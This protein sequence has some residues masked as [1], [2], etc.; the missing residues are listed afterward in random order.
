MVRP[1]RRI[2]VL[3]RG[4][5][6]FDHSEAARRPLGAD[7]RQRAGARGEDLALEG[8]AHI[9]GMQA[10]VRHIRPTAPR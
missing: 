8:L 1:R 7:L 5:G 9:F 2:V 10:A 4:R 3:R 6:H